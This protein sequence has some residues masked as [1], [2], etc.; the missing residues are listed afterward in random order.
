[1]RIAVSSEGKSENDKVSEVSGRAAYY[2]I[3]ENKNLFKVLKNPFRIGGGGAG[4]GVAEM[5]AEEKVELV[6]SGRFG[7]NMKSAL[8]SKGIKYRE[9]VNMTVR[10][11]IEKLNEGD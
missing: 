3:F 8:E 10:E 1:M 2:L 9:M 6:V 4:F 11:V 5:L 7:Q